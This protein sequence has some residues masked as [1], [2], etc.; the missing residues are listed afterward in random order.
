[1]KKNLIIVIIVIISISISMIV[2]STSTQYR[3]SMVP[4]IEDGLEVSDQSTINLVNS[5]V[6]Q[7]SES[8]QI[9][10]ENI[11]YIIDENGNKQYVLNVTDT[12]ILED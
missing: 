7:I 1:M 9:V 3:E 8:V 11:N 6:A 2:L 12:P 10:N 5:D 4:S